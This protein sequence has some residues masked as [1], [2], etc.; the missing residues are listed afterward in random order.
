[1]KTAAA[2]VLVTLLGLGAKAWPQAEVADADLPKVPAGFGA[3]VI[4]VGGEVAVEGVGQQPNAR[5]S[6]RVTERCHGNRP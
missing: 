2:L 4:M 6:V 5:A 3:M 1:M